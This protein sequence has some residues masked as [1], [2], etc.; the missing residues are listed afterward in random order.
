MASHTTVDPLSGTISTLDGLLSSRGLAC[1]VRAGDEYGGPIVCISA[2]AF[3]LDENISGR[4]HHMWLPLPVARL[5][6]P[7]VTG[8][9]TGLGEL[10]YFV[11]V[12][13][14]LVTCQSVSLH[15]VSFKM[16]IARAFSP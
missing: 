5:W 14:S 9:G 2:V 10:S 3:A 11:Y 6:S 8:G 16:Q 15:L 1:T 12:Y 7:R 4:Y 13:Q